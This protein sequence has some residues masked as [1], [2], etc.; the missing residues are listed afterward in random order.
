MR[1]LNFALREHYNLRQKYPIEKAALK[2]DI[3]ENDFKSPLNKH[4]TLVFM[5]YLK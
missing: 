4:R 2:F 3:F 1:I 5:T